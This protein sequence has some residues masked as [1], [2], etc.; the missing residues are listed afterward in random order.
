[1]QI[2]RKKIR[3]VPFSQRKRREY[4]SATHAVNVFFIEFLIQLYSRIYTYTRA[5]VR[6]TSQCLKAYFL[7][8]KIKF[9]NIMIEGNKHI[10]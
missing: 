10:Y 1:M 4:W 2:Q 8:W 3:R 7:L 9:E 6:T 5:F